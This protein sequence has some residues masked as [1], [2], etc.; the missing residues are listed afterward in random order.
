MRLGHKQ[1]EEVIFG[2]TGFRRFTQDSPILPDV[3]M[4]Y[5]LNPREPSDLLLTPTWGAPPGKLSNVIADRLEAER[6][7]P[8]WETVERSGGALDPEIA[9]NVSAVAVK[10][11]FD[12]MIRVVLPMTKWWDKYVLVDGGKAFA[13]VVGSKAHRAKT[14]ASP[15]RT[16]GPRRRA[17]RPGAGAARLLRFMLKSARVR[18]NNVA[19]AR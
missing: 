16:E 19:P 5:G 7:A 18:R 13:Q 17:R 12:E 4:A 2:K 8:R 11:Y 15:S 10:L 3:W 6:R 1:L 14:S 9:Y